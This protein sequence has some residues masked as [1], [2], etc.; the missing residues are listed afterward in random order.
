M[1]NNS[2]FEVDTKSDLKFFMRSLFIKVSNRSKNDFPR[3]KK[4]GEKVI[5]CLK[6]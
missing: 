2:V 6:K 1:D 3:I 4:R 5:S